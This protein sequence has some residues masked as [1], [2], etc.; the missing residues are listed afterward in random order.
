MPT[1]IE[2]SDESWNPIRARLLSDPSVIG[3]HCEHAS[4]GCENCYSETRNRSGRCNMGT[5]LPYKP[6]HRKDIEVFLDEAQLL[7]PL[8][9]KKGRKVFVCSMTDLFAD[10]V[11][12]EM[13][14][15][16]FA[17]MALCPQH[18]FQVLTKRA[19]RMRDYLTT[20]RSGDVW[21]GTHSFGLSQLQRRERLDSHCR[22]Q[23]FLPFPNVWLGVSVEDQQRADERIPDLLATPAAFRWI[24]AEPLLGPVDL[25]KVV[26]GD[27]SGERESWN[28]LHGAWQVQD[29]DHYRCGETAKLDLVVVGGESGKGARPMHPD[30]ARSLRDQCA[31]ASVPFFFKQWGEYHPAD[32]R[33]DAAQI[34][35]MG[36]MG[37][38]LRSGAAHAFDDQWT[39]KI[40]KKRAGRL[41]DGVEHN[42]MPA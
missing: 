33:K 42:G 22:R 10:F 12:D 36:D 8:R 11:S 24:S 9:W 37:T 19:G 31:A 14:D 6:G 5:K 26:R 17:M 25:T 35:A 34:E 21:R 4:P 32:Q 30:W 29:G 23:V 2:W 3:W 20:G 27:W 7:K 41:L 16:I 15:R 18:T 40:G 28:A 38:A 39:W 13:L 1:N